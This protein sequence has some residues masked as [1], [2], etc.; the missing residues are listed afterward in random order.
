MAAT[1]VLEEMNFE[2]VCGMIRDSLGFDDSIALSP[3][4]RL[5]ELGAEDMDYIDIAH[6]LGVT[7]GNYI[8]DYE[9]RELTGQHTADLR[10][11]SYWEAKRGNHFQA[12]HLI[13]LSYARDIK[14]LESKITIADCVSIG[15]YAREKRKKA[16]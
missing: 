5:D 13:T 14:E 9:T 16:A 3:Q 1:P 10:F 2:E 8:K 15:G 11:V 12:K 6:K 7:V 4:T